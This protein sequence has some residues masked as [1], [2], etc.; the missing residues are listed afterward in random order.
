MTWNEIRLA[1]RHGYGS[2]KLPLDK[3]SISLPS[4]FEDEDH[5]T[6][7]RY[8]GLLPMVGVRRRSTFHILAI[9]R[10]FG[11]LYDHGD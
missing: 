11:E 4:S 7:L 2:E 3:L 6:V 8:D 10:Q 1:D 5:V 9:E